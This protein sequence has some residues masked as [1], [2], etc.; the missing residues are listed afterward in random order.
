MRRQTNSALLACHGTLPSAYYITCAG[1]TDG[2]G[3]QIQAIFSTMLYAHITGIAYLHTPIR[4]VE[5]N[6]YHDADWAGKWERAFSPGYG[7]LKSG[8]FDLNRMRPLQV[9]SITLDRLEAQPLEPTLLVADECHRYADS[10]PDFYSLIRPRIMRKYQ[11]NSPP[12]VRETDRLT[13]AIHIRRGD[14]TSRDTDRYTLDS[15]IVNQINQLSRQLAALPHEFHVYSEGSEDDLGAIRNRAEMHLDGDVFDCLHSLISAD[16]FVM[17]KSSFSYTAALLSRGVVIYTPF[18]H[19][20]LQQW[21]IGGCEGSFSVRSFQSALSR[22]LLLR[23]AR[24]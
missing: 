8:A 17:A 19:S 5:H 20:P 6:T 22:H 10:H 1:R 9:G 16:I 12:I 18:W 15:T 11:L 4:S 21:I 14:V 3:A 24:G 7:E 2:G 23:T 13:I